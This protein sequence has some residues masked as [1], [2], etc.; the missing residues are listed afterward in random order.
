MEEALEI[1]K[2]ERKQKPWKIWVTVLGGVFFG[3]GAKGFIT[4][5]QGTRDPLTISAYVVLAFIGLLMVVGF[6]R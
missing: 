2:Q 3:T 6:Q 1:I 5:L 4:E